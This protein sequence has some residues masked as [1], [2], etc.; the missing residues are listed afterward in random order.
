MKNLLLIIILFLPLASMSEVRTSIQND[1][2]WHTTTGEPIYCQGGGIFRFTDPTNHTF[3]SQIGWRNGKVALL[4]CH[5]IFKGAGREGNCMFKY[6]GKYYACASNL[7]GWNASNVYYLESGNIYGPYL[8]ADKM[9]NYVKNGSFDAN[10][11]R[12]PISKKPDQDFMTGWTTDIKKGNK[13]AVGSPNTPLLNDSNSADDRKTVKG[14]FCLNI[15]SASDGSWHD[16]QIDNL[17]IRGGKVEIGFQ[18]EGKALSW[19]HI[20]DVE[21]T[22]SP[23]PKTFSF[24]KGADTSSRTNKSPKRSS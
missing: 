17:N 12:I 20:D 11:R 16:L 10:R 2:F 23:S 1:T 4:D 21:L 7:Y 8:P 6:K 13:V 3:L 24:V 5:E 18:A 9:N 19:C 14:N 22:K 15:I